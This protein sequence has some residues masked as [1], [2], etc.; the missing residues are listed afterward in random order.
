M[1]MPS[2]PGREFTDGDGEKSAPVA[3]VDGTMAAQYWRPSD[4]VGRSM[5]VN[6]ALV[7]VVGGARTA[8]Y[9]NLLETA[10]PFFYGPLRQVPSAAARRTVRPSD[11]S[12]ASGA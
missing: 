8:K 7:L 4:P 10:T 11:G 5:R 2:V 12:S 3:I 9:R 6:G 1:G